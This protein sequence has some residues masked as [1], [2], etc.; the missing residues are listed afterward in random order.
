MPHKRAR[1]EDQRARDASHEAR[2]APVVITDHT[3]EAALLSLEVVRGVLL[4]LP[5][6]ALKQA[7]S[8]MRSIV[9]ELAI[10]VEPQESNG[11]LASF[12]ATNGQSNFD[13]A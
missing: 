12:D 5:R 4:L 9:C 7:L 8:R 6:D 13:P 10:L 2:R 3:P 1:V 11:G